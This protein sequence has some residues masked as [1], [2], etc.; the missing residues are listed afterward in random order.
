MRKVVDSNFLQSDELRTYLSSSRQ[1]KVVLNDYA[2]M[3]AYKGDT[4]NS[5]YHSMEILV[6]HPKQVIVLKSTGIVC[7]LRGRAAGLQRRMID[8]RQTRQ[9][10][11]YS[12]ALLAAKRGNLSLERQL[13]DLGRE[14]TVQMDRVLADI[15]DMPDVIEDMAKIY[16]DAE[17][18]I[19]RKANRLPM[20]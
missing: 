16:S 2:S 8:E 18:K 6:Q 7:G 19:F 15:V 9:F 10:S 20:K 11:E 17:L 13:V 12:Q 4:L 3:E 14:A 5:I 1:N